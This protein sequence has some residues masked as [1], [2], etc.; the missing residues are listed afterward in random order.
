[1]ATANDIY[2]PICED[3]C[4]DGGLVLGLVTE[5]QFLDYLNLSINEFLKRSCLIERIWTQTIFAG[6]PTYAVP[7]TFVRVDNVFVGGRFLPK[8][9]QRELNAT[10]KNW[11]RT[12]GV[13]KF[14]YQD[15]MP[16]NTIGLAPC[17]N[18]NG[19][20]IQGPHDPGPPAGRFDTF[21]PLVVVDSILTGMPVDQQRNLI[22]VGPCSYSPNGDFGGGDNPVST[23]G[24]TIPLLPD[25]F[26][27]SYLEFGVLERIFS[28]DNEQKD[29]Q[30]A[31]FCGAQFQEGVVVSHAISGEE[32]EE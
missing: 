16:S 1:M 4:E 11:R 21:A 17:P 24:S 31:L 19:A 25:D 13:P 3:L 9:T 15:G 6:Q 22:I 10:L 8:S 28:G 7:D 32:S 27:L 23:L 26:A 5:Q 29:Q 12:Q 2:L 20:F 18:Y 30:K 14:W